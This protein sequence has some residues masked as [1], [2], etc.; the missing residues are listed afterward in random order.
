MEST[1][2]FFLLYQATELERS[3]LEGYL[4]ESHLRYYYLSLSV[5]PALLGVRG[6]TL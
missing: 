2:L 6:N 4:A 5:L 3:S 1:V